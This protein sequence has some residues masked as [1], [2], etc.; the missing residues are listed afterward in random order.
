M[1]DIRSRMLAIDSRAP[2]CVSVN[3][4]ALSTLFF[5]AV[6]TVMACFNFIDT[7]RPPGSSDGEFIRLPLERRFKL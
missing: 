7:A 5:V 6:V 2:S 4:R 1:V 3:E